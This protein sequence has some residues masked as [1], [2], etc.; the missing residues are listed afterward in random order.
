M[1]TVFSQS[2]NNQ[3]DPPLR[4]HWLVL[5]RENSMFPSTADKNSTLIYIWYKQSLLFPF[6]RVRNGYVLHTIK[7]LL[8][9]RL[10]FFSFKMGP[11]HQFFLPTN[12]KWHRNVV[13]MYY[14]KRNLIIKC[15]DGKKLEASFSNSENWLCLSFLF[16]IFFFM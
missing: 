16:N 14:V 6:K 3:Q 10:I 4:L 2:T 9:K 15:R 11:H 8:S 13:K 12:Y 1:I 5:P 7:R